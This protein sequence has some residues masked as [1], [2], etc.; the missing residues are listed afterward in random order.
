MA[1]KVQV[2]NYRG[3][4][5]G[6][7]ELAPI[8][9]VAGPNGAGK[10]S[11]AQA[12][13]AALTRNPAPIAGVKRG[14]AGV[15]L[16]EGAKRGSCSVSGDG[17]VATVNWPGGSVSAEGDPPEATEYGVGLASLAELKPKELAA[18]LDRLLD[19][20]PTREQL[21]E[22]LAAAGVGAEMA[23]A[24]ADRV[25]RDGYDAALQRAKS[26]ATEGKGAWEHITGERWGQA[27]ADGWRARSMP[28]GDQPLEEL[29]EAA[30]ARHENAELALEDAIA[31]Q[32]V[33]HSE[34]QR[35][36]SLVVAGEQA[37]ALLERA[38]AEL[39][40]V[41]AEA[42]AATEAHGAL[43]APGAAEQTVPCPHC[44]GALVIAPHGRSV[45]A[46]S[47]EAPTP[48]Q[49]EAAARARADAWAVCDAASARA[50]AARAELDRIERDMAAGER[51]AQ[52]LAG[53]PEGG[54]SAQDVADARAAASEAELA[55]SA[56]QRTLQ[57]GAKHAEILQA[58]AI[59]E[60]LEPSGIRQQALLGEL[61]ALDDALHDA[62]VA[63]G[64]S[65]VSI[66]PEVGASYG[67]RPYGLL[68]ESEKFRVRA[69][70]QATTA[71]WAR[72]PVLVVDAADILDRDGRN[73][74]FAL[75]AHVG[76]PALVCMT[77]Q[78]RADVPDLEQAGIGES[79]WLSDNT[80]HHAH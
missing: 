1:I 29:L 72:E 8:A 70:I 28:G 31:D 78:R 13:A 40:R 15:L 43:P 64:W 65:T 44:S 22:A 47:A 3:V 77:I 79:Y 42:K 26:R 69:T 34:V 4:A 56:I 39:E 50:R 2:K 45:R 37:G 75:L 58:L 35:L 48:E 23:E 74:L 68:S 24:V 49:V 46:P 62:S 67:G 7:F 17:W 71:V 32:A 51:A 6:E 54:T 61:Q 57:A 53:M 41:S 19:A 80:I 36:R 76:I 10:S 66:S 38:Q 59:A 25:A 18:E 12:A 63:A 30:R 11:I 20:R 16:R 9:L 73:G 33:D 60:V 21:I 52:Q 14:D 5:Q 27:K 55:V